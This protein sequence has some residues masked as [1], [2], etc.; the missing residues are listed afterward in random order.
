MS[1]IFFASFSVYEAK[2]SHAALVT[3]GDG[4]N[5]FTMEFVTIANPGNL[6]DI[7]GIPNPAGSVGYEYQIGKF[8]VS[9]DMITKYNT[10]FGSLN[11]LVIAS[12]SRGPNKPVTKIGWNEAARFINWLNSS[13]GYPNAYKFAGSDINENII[14]WVASDPGYDSANPF[15]NRY[16]RYALPSTDE[17]YK[18]AYYDP[19]ANSGAGGYWN[20]PTGSNIAPAAVASGT[21]AGTAVFDGQPA[22]PAE[23][24]QAGGL[25]PYGV[26]GLGGNVVEWEESAFDLSNSVGSELRGIRGGFWHPGAIFLSV[27]QRLSFNPS[28]ADDNNI[29]FRVVSIPQASNAVPEPSMMLI[30]TFFSLMGFLRRS[31]GNVSGLRKA[32]T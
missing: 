14:L 22:G 21:T 9:E 30:G 3:F 8:E 27:S 11:G 13:S 19:S 29:G 24:N 17:W 28:S 6:A 23:V 7:S 25:S 12:S 32:G 5:Q 26:M 10:N 20:F 2:S 31:G 18:A 16:A 1:I 15:R 4:A